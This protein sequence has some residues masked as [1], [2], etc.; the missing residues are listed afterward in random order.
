MQNS[1]SNI[2]VVPIKYVLI[3]DKQ[4]MG[5][6]SQL[7]MAQSARECPGPGNFLG[8]VWGIIQEKLSGVEIIRGG[9][10]LKVNCPVTKI[11][12]GIRG[13]MSRGKHLGDFQITCRI[14]SLYVQRL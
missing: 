11:S 13:I 12:G 8:D 4:P 9:G 6:D 7:A 10:Y 2:I 5:Y 3:S 14:I 1:T